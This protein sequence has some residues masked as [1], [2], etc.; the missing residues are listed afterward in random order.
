MGNAAYIGINEGMIR[1]CARF[2]WIESCV[3][4]VPSRRAH[5]G[6]LE[7]PSKPQTLFC[8]AIDVWRVCLTSITTEIQ[9]RAIISNHKQKIGSLVL[10]CHRIGC[11][12]ADKL[13]E[14]AKRE[15]GDQ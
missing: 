9:V 2:D 8:E 14:Q 15:G 13:R 10:L 7:A 3:E 11:Q 5:C 1:P 12:W 6:G 4:R